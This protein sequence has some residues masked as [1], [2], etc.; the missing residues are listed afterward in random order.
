MPEIFTGPAFATATGLL[1]WALDEGGT[2][3]N[4]DPS[5]GGRHGWFH[6]FVNF[7]RDRV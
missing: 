5:R 4:A 7:I 1:N 2:F 3:H 6:R